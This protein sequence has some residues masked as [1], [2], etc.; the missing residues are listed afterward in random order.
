MINPLLLLSKNDIPFEQAQLI[1]HQPILKQI[2][3][4]G[5]ETFFTGCKYLNFSKENLSE[6][7]KNNLDKLTNFEV[8][9]TIMRN[10]DIVVKKS[11]IC[12]LQVLALLF[13]DYKIDLL[14]MSIRIF[15][16]DDDAIEQHLIDKENFESFRKI[17]SQMFCLQDMEGS[18]SK[19]NPAGPQAR[20]IVQKFKQREKK[21]AK[22]RQRGHE[23]ETVSILSQYISILAVGQKKD[24]NGLLQYTVY[25]LFDEFRRFRLKQDFDI[26]VKAKMAGAKDLEDVKNWMENIHSDIL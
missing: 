16:K 13:P 19:Y 22:I 14:P 17:V 5:E 23:N 20:A 4:I 2:A 24:M 6:Q 11:K 7:D 10:K 1:I 15:K 18:K 9:M 3:Y 8:L 25:Q 26:Y 21:L 12:M